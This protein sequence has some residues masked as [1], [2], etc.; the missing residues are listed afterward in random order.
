MLQ[1]IEGQIHLNLKYSV[2]LC[3]AK[4]CIKFERNR[5]VNFQKQVNVKGFLSSFLSFF[6]F[7]SFSFFLCFFLFFFSLF[8]FTSFFLKYEI[9]WVGCSPMHI[10]QA[11]KMSLRFIKLITL[12]SM[13][14]LTNIF[15]LLLLLLHSMWWSHQPNP[16]SL[17]CHILVCQA[18]SCCRPAELGF[19]GHATGPYLLPCLMVDTAVQ[20]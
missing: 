6:F 12:N 17:K 15:L 8:A 18:Q 11:R 16:P 9:T 13:P 20:E 2:K 5:L 19:G 1:R 3:I 4:Y 14:S 10:T 7:L